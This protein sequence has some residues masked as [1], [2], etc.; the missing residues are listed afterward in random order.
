MAQITSGVRAMLSS[1]AVYDTFQ[2][3]MGGHAGRTDFANHIVKALAGTR[4]LDVGCGTGELLAYLPQGVD[5]HGWDISAA[6]VTAARQRFGARGTF[7]C[8]LLT[9]ADV[10]SVPPFEVVIA[11]GVLHHLDDDEARHFA[12]LAALAVRAGGRFASIDPVHAR[13]QHPLA[14]YLIA[15]DRGQHVRTAEGYTSLV[16]G[17]FSEVTGVVRHRRWVPYTHWMMEATYRPG[18]AASRKS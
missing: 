3:L 2:R 17:A 11:S 15:R 6:Y 9:E 10:T 18:V 1:P 7:T 5:Y 8:G 14:R 16:E 4:V 13:G 12:A